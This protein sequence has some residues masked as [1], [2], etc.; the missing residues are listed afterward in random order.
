MF[1]ETIRHGA[2]GQ[3][4][5]RLGSSGLHRAEWPGGGGLEDVQQTDHNQEDAD[6]L[7]R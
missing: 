5:G 3:A 6:K 2:K 4:E 1:R 7:G